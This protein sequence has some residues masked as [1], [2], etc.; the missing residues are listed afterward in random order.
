[1]KFSKKVMS[2]ALCTVLLSGGGLASLSNIAHA[3]SNNAICSRSAEGCWTETINLKIKR[4]SSWEKS[5]LQLNLVSSG[6]RIRLEYAGYVPSL[7]D[8][9]FADDYLFGTVSTNNGT[10]FKR[11]L[12]NSG[13]GAFKNGNIGQKVEALINDFNNANVRTNDFMYMHGTKSNDSMTFSGQEIKRPSSKGYENGYASRGI[14]K[15][16]NGFQ[17]LGSGIYE[18]ALINN[19]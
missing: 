8:Y 15:W 13:V 11:L 10:N 4:K 5:T 3:D 1:M 6:G 19:K 18:C 9:E 17:L 12:D 2:V 7:Y 16:K 14:D